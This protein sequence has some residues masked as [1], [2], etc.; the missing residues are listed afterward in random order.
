MCMRNF[1]SFT[2]YTTHVD[3]TI[4]KRDKLP[5]TPDSDQNGGGGGGGG[6]LG[7]VYGDWKCWVAR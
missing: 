5:K 1:P 3:S 6:G 4:N 7:V 2:F